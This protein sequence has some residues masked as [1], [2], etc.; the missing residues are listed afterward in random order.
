[1][2]KGLKSKIFDKI[3]LQIACLFH[4][5][6]HPNGWEYTKIDELVEEEVHD[7]IFMRVEVIEDLKDSTLDSAQPIE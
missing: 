5:M 7:Q 3:I 6:K 2:S 4:G 1:M